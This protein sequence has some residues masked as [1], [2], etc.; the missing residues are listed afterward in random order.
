MIAT[1]INTL[2]QL[3]L[4]SNLYHTLIHIEQVQKFWH[5][6]INNNFEVEDD[7]SIIQL[8]DG[9]FWPIQERNERTLYVRECTKDIYNLIHKG[10]GKVEKIK[11]T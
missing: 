5:S 9:V 1:L 10:A 11:R 3:I 4:Q 7:E 6:H 8:S 2:P